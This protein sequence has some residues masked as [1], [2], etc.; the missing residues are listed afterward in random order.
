MYGQEGCHACE[1]QKQLL[2][3]SFSFVREVD[4]AVQSERCT[5]QG[6]SATPTWVINGSFRVGVQTPEQLANASGCAV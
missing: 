2:G 1:Y 3:S 5:S 6:V 4:C